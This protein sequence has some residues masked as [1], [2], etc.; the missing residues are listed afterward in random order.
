MWVLWLH[1]NSTT[2]VP[3]LER[4]LTFTDPVP[5]VELQTDDLSAITDGVEVLLE[6]DRVMTGP[7]N[8]DFFRRGFS[9]P[10]LL[11]CGCLGPFPSLVKSIGGSVR[12]QQVP[13][14]A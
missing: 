9:S 14:Q 11:L 13:R 10:G 1:S 5:E 12:P 7:P 8:H 6:L 4:D 3:E 2:S